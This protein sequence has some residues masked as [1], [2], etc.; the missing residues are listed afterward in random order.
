MLLRQ[1]LLG[2]SARLHILAPVL[3]GSLLAYSAAHAQSTGSQTTVQEVVITAKHTKSIGG[4]AVPVTTAKDTSIITQDYTK[5]L[6]GSSNFAQ[7]IDTLP[8]VTYS[9]EDPT[10]VLSSDFRLHG[11][12]GD[13]VSFT[14]DGTP[15]N[16]TGNYAIFPGE[17]T[18]SEVI[19]HVTVNIGQTEIDSP[20][21]SALGGTVNIVGKTPSNTFGAYGSVAGG[22]YDYKRGF[23]EIDSGAIGPFGTKA[24]ASVNYMDADKY[25]GEGQLTGW[26]SDGKIYQP[27]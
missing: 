16:D 11:V 8:G 24:Y 26:G 25:K 23:A 9:T 7:I 5:H 12:P 19:D 18:P 15:L 14:L 17:Y 20:S 21:A 13:H 6:P 1:R 4:L 2:H 10:G 27:L 3:M 22:S